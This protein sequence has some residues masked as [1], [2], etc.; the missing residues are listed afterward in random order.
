MADSIHAVPRSAERLRNGVAEQG[1]QVEEQP[2]VEAGRR[3]DA[4]GDRQVIIIGAVLKSIE[5]P[6]IDCV[7][8]RQ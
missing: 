4:A 1:Q 2:D 8:S 5:T 3:Q 7:Y 6:L